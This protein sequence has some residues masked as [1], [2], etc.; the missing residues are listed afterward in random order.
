[1]THYPET[2]TKNRY[3]KTRTGFLQVCHAVRYRFFFWYRNLVRVRALLYS[4]D[5]TDTGFLVPVFGTVF[6]I[7]CHGPKGLYE[8]WN[9]ALEHDIGLHKA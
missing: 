6:W 2:G 1:M 9:I 4:V 7:V 5:E 8:Q 3:K